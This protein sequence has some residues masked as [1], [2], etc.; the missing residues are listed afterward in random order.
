MRSIIFP[1]F[2][3]SSVMPGCGKIAMSGRLLPATRLRTSLSKSGVEESLSV[4]P[5]VLAQAF[6][7]ALKF[8][9]WSPLNPYITSTVVSPPPPPPLLPLSLPLLRQA[10]AA[11]VTAAARAT[12]SMVLRLRIP[13]PVQSCC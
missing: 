12:L 6:I 5:S 2:A 4:M 8:S 11:R 1:V 10:E 3:M 13:A 7:A 9:D